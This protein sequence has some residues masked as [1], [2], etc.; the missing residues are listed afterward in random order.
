[1]LAVRFNFTWSTD[2]A[3]SE[4]RRLCGPKMMLGV[5]VTVIN[6]QVCKIQF[7][8][9]ASCLMMMLWWCCYYSHEEVV[10]MIFLYC[11]DVC[12]IVFCSLHYTQLRF[13]PQLIHSLFE[14]WQLLELHQ[15]V[16]FCCC[17]GPLCYS[18]SLFK[19]CLRCQLLP[20]F[21]KLLFMWRCVI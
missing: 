19:L 12:K 6:N 3:V 8:K 17:W 1:M 4:W 14:K 16:S 11:D 7:A 15:N 10:N 2:L 13:P 21:L 18:F 9:L 5:L 20:F